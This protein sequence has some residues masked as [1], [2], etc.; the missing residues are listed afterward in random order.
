MV[1]RITRLNGASMRETA[2]QMQCKTAEIAY[3]IGCREMGIYH[4]NAAAESNEIL[5]SRLDGVIA[6]LQWGDIVICQFPTWNGL[7]FERALVDRIK[8]YRGYVVIFIHDV[9]AMMFESN[10]YLLQEIIDLYNQAEVL[11]VPSYSMKEFLLENGLRTN[12]KI[13]VQE[14]WDYTTD[15]HFMDSP[16]LRK[17]IHFAGDLGRFLFPHQWDYAIPLK[18]YSDKQCTGKNVQLMGWM[19]PSALLLELAKGGFGLLWPGDDQ[20]RKYMRYNNNTKL[21]TYLAAGIPVIIPR[22]GISNQ[23]IIE[24]NNLGLLVDSLEEAV[25]KVQKVTEQEYQEYINHVSKFAVLL[26]NGYFTQKV[27]L[28]AIHLVHREDFV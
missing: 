13:A 19:N 3:R 23:N 6:G 7:R 15:I 11:I 1:V 24:R 20:M 18:V 9:V 25:E 21:S 4:Y 22:Q 12:M 2:M 16:K 10:Q 27:L 8:A 28:E 26:R 5:G 17:E 14:M